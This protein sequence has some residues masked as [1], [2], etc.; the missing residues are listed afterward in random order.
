MNSMFSN[1]KFVKVNANDI[2]WN[3]SYLE[4]GEDYGLPSIVQNY[5][6]ELDEDVDPSERWCEDG[7][8]SGYEV[9]CEVLINQLSDEYGV[10]I[11]YIEDVEVIE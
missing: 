8:K 2:I 11:I 9:L 4:Y 3:D 5:E 6:V 10:G 7:H 1:K